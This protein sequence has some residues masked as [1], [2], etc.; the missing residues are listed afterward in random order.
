M[1]PVSPGLPDPVGGRHSAGSLTKTMRAS[2]RV[3]AGESVCRTRRPSCRLSRR[4]GDVTGCRC[5]RC[6]ATCLLAQWARPRDLFFFSAERQVDL[7]TVAPS[8]WQ[9]FRTLMPPRLYFDSCRHYSF[10]CR[11]VRRLMDRCSQLSTF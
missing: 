2:G 8:A 1:E 11:T 10:Q 5:D 3:L 7:K 9:S 6:V 4:S